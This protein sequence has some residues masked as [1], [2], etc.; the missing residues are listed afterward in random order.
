MVDARRIR[1]L[2]AFSVG[3]L[4]LAAPSALGQS[5]YDR[6]REIERRISGLREEIEAARAK[7]GVLTTEIEAASQRI[8]ALGGDIDSLSALIAKLE[9]EVAEH[10]RKLE[11][12]RERFEEQTRDLEHLKRQFA[13]AQ[14]QLEERLV[15]LYQSDETDAFGILLQVQSLADLLDQIEYFDSIGRQDQAITSELDRLKGEMRIAREKTRLTKVEVTKE[16]EALERKTAEQVAARQALVAQQNALAAARESQQGLLAN[17]KHERHEDQEDLS[18]LQAA[19]AALAAQI[20]KSQSSGG[21]STGSGTSSSGFIWPVN[22]VVTS[23]FGWRWG[24]MHEGIDI[25]AP[26]GTTIRA[27]ASGTVIYAGWMGGYGNLTIVDHG[28]GLAT[29]YAHQSSIYVGGGSVSQ[30][31]ALGAVGCT[32]SCTG[33]HLHFE[34]RVNGSAVDPMGYL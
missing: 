26:A 19:S 27:V 24:R 5:A 17:V 4:V 33:N 1:L 3:L 8:E 31:Q 28:D 7:E 25:S 11:Q 23:G 34:V 14:R 18:A 13:I 32:G 21:G 9:V 16:T 29:A 2:L 12:L 15:E 20:R 22:G 6:Q 30:G 10:R